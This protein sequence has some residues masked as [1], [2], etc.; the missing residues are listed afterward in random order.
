MYWQG[1]DA[2]AGTSQ[3]GV[4][5][6]VLAWCPPVCLQNETCCCNCWDWDW[7]GL[8]NKVLMVRR[9]GVGKVCAGLL[10]QGTAAGILGQG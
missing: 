10:G 2:T 1:L 3:V 4:G 8:M 9:H 5:H 6:T 7:P